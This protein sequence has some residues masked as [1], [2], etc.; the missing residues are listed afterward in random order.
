[1]NMSDEQI[2]K[3]FSRILEPEVNSVS[4]SG[5]SDPNF[6]E[7]IAGEPPN[8]APG[9]LHGE[10]IGL[11]EPDVK[12]NIQERT[13]RNIAD[14]SDAHQYPPDLPAALPSEFDL[15]LSHLFTGSR[16]APGKNTPYPATDSSGDI[17]EN[18]AAL[19]ECVDDILHPMDS[20]ANRQNYGTFYYVHENVPPL[21]HAA[22]KTFDVHSV[23]RDFP[24][25]HQ[26]VHGNKQLI[27]LDNAATTQKPRSVIDAT[28]VFYER[29]NSN[30]HRGAHALAARATD[31]YE[32]ARESIRLYIGARR[33]CEI[34][35]VRG[36][37]EA[38]NLVAKT[39]GRK[40]VGSGEE[41]IITEMEHHANIVPWQMLCEETGAVLRVAP[42]N[43]AGELL[44]D[45]YAALLNQKTKLVAFTQVSN[46]LGTVNPVEMMTR[47][48]HAAG[49]RVLIDGAQSIP[50][51]PVNVQSIDCDFFTF[52]G[53]KLF[54]PTGIGVLF[55][56]EELLEQMPPWEGGGNMIKNVTFEKTSYNS[57]PHKFEAG[58]HNI[59]G[60]VG[61][62]AAIEYLSGIDTQA[63]AQYEQG[64]LQY[65]MEELAAIPGM[66]LIGTAPGKVSVVSFVLEGFANEDVGKF[67]D[68]EGIAVRASHH[69]AQPVL[70]HYGLQS[71]VRPS[72]AFYNTCDEID[73]L[74]RALLKL[75]SRK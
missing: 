37:T 56:K 44:L 48:A 34:I 50:H 45:R 16:P 32:N 72:L 27:W 22:D 64:V 14:S 35:F 70:K 11:H 24:A 26:K 30:I 49:A 54:G 23:R 21:L 1:M 7:K 13:G 43:D 63:A 67:L 4:H 9:L 58:T 38:I 8:E 53:H 41:I 57:L 6:M 74:V 51:F 68:R 19:Q 42:M 3:I 71:S 29:D 69:C 15:D 65:A 40:C 25:L 10:T 20:S 46:V 66:R 59:A 36:T 60:A 17:W 33:S 52:S 12:G 2:K 28:R 75:K 61:L 31:A 18:T 62:G 73:A 47:M 39:Y 55:G 5:F